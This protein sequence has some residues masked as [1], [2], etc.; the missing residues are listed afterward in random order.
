[1][2]ILKLTGLNTKIVIIPD[3]SVGELA[4]FARLL[5]AILFLAFEQAGDGVH[6][7]DKCCLDQ[8]FKHRSEG[9]RF[10]DL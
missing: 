9:H 5:E 7:D 8:L 6:G 3:L 4:R 1:M 2:E 10:H